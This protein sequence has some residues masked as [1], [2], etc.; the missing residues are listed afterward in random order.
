VN[1]ATVQKS[2]AIP[3]SSCSPRG[4]R[5]A[6]PFRVAP[7]P[8][9]HP[10]F[11]VAMKWCTRRA[12]KSFHVEVPNSTMQITLDVEPEQYMP[13]ELHAL[14]ELLDSSSWE[15]QAKHILKLAFSK[16]RLLFHVMDAKKIVA[17]ARAK[18]MARLR[19]RER[20]RLRYQQRVR[21]VTGRRHPAVAVPK[22]K[23]QAHGMAMAIEDEPLDLAGANVEVA[24]SLES[25]SD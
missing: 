3:G 22:A 9:P 5:R 17:R 10:A 16:P 14:R 12:G 2:A 20:Q 23:A 6:P 11:R 13:V 18:E 8:T 25:D 19:E 4:Q 1:Q 21:P 24:L 15:E 7:E